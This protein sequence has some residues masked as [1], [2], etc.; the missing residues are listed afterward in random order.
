MPTIG[1]SGG[2]PSSGLEKGCRTGED[3]PAR[4]GSD[5][6]ADAGWQEDGG[7][8][9]SPSGNSDSLEV[10]VAGVPAGQR[11]TLIGRNQFLAQLLTGQE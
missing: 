9:I 4:G 6:K 3:P 2:P 7:R 8:P 5:E 10:Q 11:H 1:L